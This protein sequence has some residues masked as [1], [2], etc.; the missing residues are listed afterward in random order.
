MTIGSNII[1]HA[2]VSSTNEL[3]TDLI[4]NGS[5]TDGTVISAGF[6]LKGKGQRNKQWHSDPF[7]NLIM[8]VILKPNG[9]MPED[10]FYIS[11]IISLSIIDT[12]GRYSDKFSIK[13]PNDIYHKGD[14]I[15]GIL[16]ENTIIGNRISASIAGI[17][18]N[19]NQKDFPE[20]LPN[21]VSLSTISAKNHNV[22]L[23]QDEVCRNLQN[24][25]E[26]LIAEQY[27]IIDESYENRLYQSGIE[28]QYKTKEGR[29]SGTIL[30]VNK[31]GQL[32]L[33]CSSG[34]KRIFS[35]KEIEFRPS[36][37]TSR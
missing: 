21:P 22:Q 13:W 3:A 27:D 20:D 16:I 9:L 2:N 7:M 29:I 12:L 17:G 23:I 35:F 34:E 31:S 18:L 5:A 11:K 8:S 4:S 30:G 33:L 15:A 10:Q 26:A 32:I 25:Y 14:K 6:Q 37:E 19:I 1:Y 24:W 28:A 36:T